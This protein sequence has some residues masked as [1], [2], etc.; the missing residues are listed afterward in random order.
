MWII[1][2]ELSDDYPMSLT[3]LAKPVAVLRSLDR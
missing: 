1:L 2:D 3:A